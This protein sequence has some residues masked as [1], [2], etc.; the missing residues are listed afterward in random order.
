[1][2]YEKS[3]D[4]LR[5]LLAEVERL[6]L[7]DGSIVIQQGTLDH[8]RTTVAQL[9]RTVAEGKALLLDCTESLKRANATVADQAAALAERDKVVAEMRKF[10]P[11]S[12]SLAYATA[13]TVIAW[14]DQLAAS[15]STQEKPK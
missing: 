1:M 8:I 13:A 11:A 4:M 15:V 5:T 7:P 6:T 2:E 9:E 14:A 10:A 3:A 12:Y